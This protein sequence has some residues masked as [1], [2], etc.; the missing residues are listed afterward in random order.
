MPRHK[1]FRAKGLV[2]RASGLGFRVPVVQV[3]SRARA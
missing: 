1:G 3:R 2:L